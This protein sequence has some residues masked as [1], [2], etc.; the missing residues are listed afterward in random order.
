MIYFSD[1]PPYLWF[2]IWLN[3]H[4][5]ASLFWRF[6]EFHSNWCYISLEKKE[7]YKHTLQIVNTTINNF[8]EYFFLSGMT[9]SALSIWKIECP[10][11]IFRFSFSFQK[12][13]CL[14]Q[15][16]DQCSAI[17]VLRSLV[18]LISDT[19]DSE[20]PPPIPKEEINLVELPEGRRNDSET[21]MSTNPPLI[22]DGEMTLLKVPDRSR[23]D[24]GVSVSSHLE[25]TNLMSDQEPDQISPRLKQVALVSPVPRE[26]G[27]S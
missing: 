17:S 4:I 15:E 10:S 22:L 19:H 24:S 6:K 20:N 12:I 18:F 25:N 14:I 23:N 27:K 1:F 2:S 9:L 26:H 11:G 3:V 13:I 7:A 8:C 16:C 5:C 21:F